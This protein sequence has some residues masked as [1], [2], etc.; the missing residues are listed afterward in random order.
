MEIVLEDE[1]RVAVPLDAAAVTVIEDGFTQLS[2]GTVQTP[3][4]MRMEFPEQ[5]G[6]V[7]V[8]AAWVEGLDQFAIK[9]SSGFFNNTVKGLR[10]SSG[11]MVVLSAITGY[12]EALLLDQGYLTDV[13]TAAA[14]AIAAKYLANDPIHTV[15]ILGSG[16]QA[17]GQLHALR[18]VRQFDRVLVFSPHRNHAQRFAEEMHH[19]L[20][21]DVHV[22]ASAEAVVREADVVVS[23]TPATQPLIDAAWLHP[24]LHITAMGSDAEFKQELDP[25]I[26]RLADKV[27]CDVTAQ[28]L[29]LGELHHAYDAGYIRPVDVTE[30]GDITAGKILG[31]THR[32]HIT[33]CDL[34]GTGVQDTM[35]AVYALERV[36]DYKQWALVN[37]PAS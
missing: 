31:R 12:P 19:T 37:G 4:I 9:L 10:S 3:P 2:Q 20:E 1:L 11:L 17:R 6:E 8:K 13:R 29:R 33:V 7:D 15:G 35:I 14:G 32:D 23:C 26:F 5:N 22:A 18:L 36:H 16:T 24:G 34:T 27:C 21:V 28:C 30:L 25:Q